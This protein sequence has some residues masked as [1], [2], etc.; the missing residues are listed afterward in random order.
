MTLSKVRRRELLNTPGRFIALFFIILLG[1]GAFAGLQSAAPAMEKTADTYFTETEAVDFRIYC[2][3]GITE[4]DVKAAQALPEVAK[5]VPAYKIDVM[6]HYGNT[7]AVY[8]IHS[9]STG[10]RDSIRARLTLTEGRL[11]ATPKECVVDPAS[12]LKVGDVVA[13]SDDN[14]AGR[15][16]L[17]AERSFTVVGLA[18]SSDYISIDRGN[19]DI[20][21]GRISNYLYV[22]EKA[23]D[24]PYFTEMDITL[25]NDEHVSA[26][27]DE[28]AELER[29]TR[30]ALDQLIEA[31]AQS[32]YDEIKKSIADQI[33]AGETEYAQT[34]LDTKNTLARAQAELR[35]GEINL[36]RGEEIYRQYGE[37]LRAGKAVIADSRKE[38]ETARV[39]LAKLVPLIEAGRDAVAEGRAT[40]N[41]LR[42]QRDQMYNTLTGTDDPNVI[43]DLQARLNVLVPQITLLET[44]ASRAES[45]LA[46]SERAFQIGQAQYEAS[47]AG[48]VA[49]EAQ[50]A[51]GE[52]ELAN[53]RAEL[54]RSALKLTTGRSQYTAESGA[55]ST[56]L[57]EARQE[58][59]ESQSL[60]DSVDMS[61]WFIRDRED[62]PG[63]SGFRSDVGR[64]GNLAFAIPWFL[65]LIAALVCLTTMTRMVEEH[66]TRIG[67]LKALGYDRISVMGLYQFYAWAIGLLGGVIGVALGVLA[68]PRAIW[69]AYGTMYFMNDFQLALAPIPC[70]IGLFG[71]TIVVA[72]ATG[73]ACRTALS[74]S[75]ASL[76]RP[77]AP[78][79]GRRVL[80]EHIPFVWKRFTFSQKV[81]VRN[82]FRYKKRFLMTVIGVAGCTALLLTGFGL[83]DSINGISDL[84]FDKIT[85][86]DATIALEKGSN[87]TAKTPLNE[88]LV[89]T[90]AAYMQISD[91]QV[92]AGSRNN[93]DLITYMYVPEKPY[94]LNRMITFR[95]RMGHRTIPFPP[96]GERPGVVITERLAK[97]LDVEEGDEI[98]F[99]L[100][101]NTNRARARVA[102]ITES[103]VY[104][105]IYVA[106][107]T[108]ETLFGTAPSFSAVL[109]SSDLS[110]TAFNELLS[111]IVATEN[112]ASAIPVSQL[113]EIM[114]EVESNISS[115][116]WI[117]ITIASAL[118]LVVLYNLVNINITEREREIA[119]LK[120]LGFYR[121]EVAAY[122]LR[123]TIVLTV[124]G[125]LFGLVIGVFLHDFVM[126]SI[127]VNEVM[128]S[129]LILPQ[130]YGFAATFTLGCSLLIGLLMSPRL[131]RIDPVG[132]L[133]SVE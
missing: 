124:I 103:Y 71:G 19:T 114:D 68:F 76:M 49:A 24:A 23:F 13:V 7:S 93:D 78:K 59:D 30:N 125:I 4:D 27:S 32:R 127:E 107:E 100:T 92:S 33:S 117:I 35:A 130:S 118:A 37:Q 97:V 17:L 89:G 36:T 66:R 121:R 22:P 128:F 39:E 108:Y 111:E 52:Q 87:A 20:G 48:T 109:L 132:S 38:L 11:P 110:E 82:L 57:D 16:E 34:M 28:Y 26:F 60:L 75:A 56:S 65:F 50:L 12:S 80:L 47:L 18:R 119:T 129:R 8:A 74:S 83:R 90:R 77:Q 95:E 2:D 15:L 70:A 44:Q 3:Q 64:I 79:P 67:T 21:S 98:T 46:A 88:K 101:T 120:V 104:N 112:V 91:A 85:Q 31:R 106:P 105:Y 43:A 1:A 84:Q 81:T 9:F 62:F 29:R 94:Q 61:E 115:V 25:A 69:N 5:A 53:L 99:G 123:E 6:A 102:G 51:T 58:L 96:P 113:R 131:N 10:D 133:K 40:L 54:D 63:Y 126:G 73:A 122:I 86:L 116:V 72:I 45:E 41:T 42:T 14:D 55:A